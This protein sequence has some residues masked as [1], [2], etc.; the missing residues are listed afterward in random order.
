MEKI[1]WVV[2]AIATL[3]SGIVAQWR[4]R[5]LPLGRLALG[6]FYVVAGAIVHC[7]YL[8]TGSSYAT[9]ADAAH[10]SFV[11]TAWHSVV[12]PNQ[13]L[14]IGLLIAFEAAAGVLVLMGGRKAQLGM[15][16]ILG[17]QAC[18][19]LFGWFLTVSGIFMLVAVG[20]L[21]RAQVHHDRTEQH[22]GVAAP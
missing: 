7:Y 10:V 15:V 16:G 1:A 14:F 19:L 6:L 17:M 21:L 20:L 5:A 3:V 11:R 18:L 9:F 13:T 12:A 22:S 2:L 4:P 8:A